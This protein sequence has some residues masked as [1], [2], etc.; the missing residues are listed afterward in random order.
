MIPTAWNRKIA[1]SLALA[2][3]TVVMAAPALA[4]DS[5]SDEELRN[6]AVAREQAR[7]K[8]LETEAVTRAN[9]ARFEMRVAEADRQL[10]ELKTNQD[11]F[12]DRLAELMKSDTGRRVAVQNQQA[13]LIIM[14]WMDAPLMRE[15]DFAER[16]G[17]ADEMVQLVEQR[18]QRPD[19]PYSVDPAQENRTDDVYLWAR[20]RASRLAERSAWL[21]DT[22]RGVDASQSVDG[23]PTLS[24]A[25]DSFMKARRDFW[26]QA[27]STGQQRAREEAEPQ[28]TEAARVAEL[29]RLLQESEQRLREARQQMETDRMQFESRLRTREAE[30]IKAAAEAEEARLNLLAETEHMQRLEAANRRLEQELSEAGA[31]DIVEEAEGVR[32]RQIA[33]SP[34]VQRDLAPFFARGTWQPNQRASQQGSAAP[35][36]IS[37]SALVEVGA[38][39]EDQQGLMQ[40]LAVA[41]AQGCAGSKSLIH[42]HQNNRHQDRERTKWGYPR[43]FRSLSAVDQD[44]VRRVQKLLRELGPTLVELG[45]LGP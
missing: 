6:R 35:G 1:R 23:A 39:A 13:G 31:R 41:N 3:C 20:E 27:T 22:T 28:M 10:R 15:A 32:L 2:V 37:F 45:L 11:A 43:Q 25:I 30:A 8:Q 34:S 9:F 44:E 38:L 19:V 36:P 7:A 4:Q 18:K 40:L 29:E 33:Q 14:G 5:L 16:R 42:W 26:A 21:G 17:F 12:T 24:E